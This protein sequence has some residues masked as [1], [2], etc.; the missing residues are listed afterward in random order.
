MLPQHFVDTI[1][2]ISNN[3]TSAP[4]SIR[5]I[6]FHCCNEKSGELFVGY[7]CKHLQDKRN[8]KGKKTCL[9]VG[10]KICYR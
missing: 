3:L 1:K 6:K 2:L 5:L 4:E 7:I 9:S 8:K 10:S